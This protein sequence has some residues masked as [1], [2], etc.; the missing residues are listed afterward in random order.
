MGYGTQIATGV[1]GSGLSHNLGDC[2]PL[3]APGITARVV[4]SFSSTVGGSVQ[5][6][7]RMVTHS[8][9]RAPDIS[10]PCPTLAVVV[11]RPDALEYV[12]FVVDASSLAYLGDGVQG[13]GR[14]RPLVIS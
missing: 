6:P 12:L 9:S 1:R 14:L 7:G 5:A 11:D 8:F 2:P 13:P 3:L 10:Y 4:R